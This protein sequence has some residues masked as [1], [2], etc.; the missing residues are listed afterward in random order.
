MSGKALPWIV[1]GGAAVA[2]GV[3]LL[4]DRFA[5]SQL[6]GAALAIAGVLGVTL[7]T[8]APRSVE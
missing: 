7:M 3:V 2:L 1:A 8:S 6:A 5:P 4:G